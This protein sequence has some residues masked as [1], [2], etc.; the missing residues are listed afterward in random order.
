LTFEVT[1]TWLALGLDPQRSIL[2]R[3]SDLAEVCE[4]AWLLGCV[5]AKGLLNRGHDYKTIVD[6]NR[7]R[8]RPP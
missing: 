3:Q 1:A 4:L 5:T 8:G 7:L 2:Y 6:D